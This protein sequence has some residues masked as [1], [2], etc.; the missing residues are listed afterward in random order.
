MLFPNN[1]IGL[2]FPPVAL[3]AKYFVIIFGAI[4]LLLGLTGRDSG[5]A[6]FAHLGGSY[7]PACKLFALITALLLL[8]AN[9]NGVWGQVGEPDDNY[10]PEWDFCYD[11]PEATIENKAD[12][13]G[14]SETIDTIYVM[15]GHSVDI[16]LQ[17]APTGENLNGYV[18]WFVENQNGVSLNNLQ[19]PTSGNHNLSPELFWPEEGLV[20]YK[21]GYAWF[22]YAKNDYENSV[23]TPHEGSAK[24]LSNIKG[25]EGGDITVGQ[26]GGLNCYITYNCPQYYDN[27]NPDIV[28]CEASSLIDF[29]APLTGETNTGTREAPT[30][31]VRRKYVIQTATERQT[32]LGTYRNNINRSQSTSSWLTYSRASLPTELR[33]NS[34]KYFKEVYSI[35][36]PIYED[37]TGTNYRLGEIM[38]N[39]FVPSSEYPANQVRWRW[40]EEDGT[41]LTFSTFKRF[42]IAPTRLSSEVTISCGILFSISPRVKFLDLIAASWN[43]ALYS[44]KLSSVTL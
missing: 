4:E 20:K 18:R 25:N 43:F 23:P 28:V 17:Y 38:D 22:R 32:Q 3:K 44:A 7:R 1:I 13:R 24:W 27:N 35:H 9:W 36:T 21:N 6:H 8:G 11:R 34:S 12:P 29:D 31:S 40:Y 5:V 41:Y 26:I 33:D 42:L 16:T 37:G 39:Y 15:P 10:H 19:R 2:V 14:L 30:L